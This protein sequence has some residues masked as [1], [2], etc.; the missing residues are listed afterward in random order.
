MISNG[1]KSHCILHVF[2]YKHSTEVH[3]PSKNK[4]HACL[5]QEMGVASHDLLYA[6]VHKYTPKV[7][8]PTKDYLHASQLLERG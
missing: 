1:G 8:S 3:L 5:Q 7:H 6:L 2:I 4:L